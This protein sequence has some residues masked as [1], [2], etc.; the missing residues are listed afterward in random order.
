VYDDPDSKVR[1]SMPDESKSEPARE[2]K[3]LELLG[4]AALF[5]LC[6]GLSPVL[7][8]LLPLKTKLDFL[9]VFDA[10]DLMALPFAFLFG[11][12]SVAPCLRSARAVLFV[13]L[14]M[15][16]LHAAIW[17]AMLGMG[18]GSFGIATM[19]LAGATGAFGVALA[20]SVCCRRLLSL[21]CL[22]RVALLGLIAAAPLAVMGDSLTNGPST[23]PLFCSV[24]A[25]WQSCVGTYLYW[26]CTV[27]RDR[28]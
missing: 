28:A 5:A 7:L 26:V 3:F 10:W 15:V 18:R 4:V 23:L 27:N 19:A 11:L 1:I 22:G 12:L 20:G 6:G 24:F 8:G 16:V 21:K 9:P 17:V 25:L 14:N 13:A 2:R